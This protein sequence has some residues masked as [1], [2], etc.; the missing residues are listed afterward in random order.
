MTWF[1]LATPA[2]TWTVRCDWCHVQMHMMFD[3]S[4]ICPSICDYA[5]PLNLHK[6]SVQMHMHLHIVREAA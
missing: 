5:F 2:P 6:D 4:R 3:S 1:M